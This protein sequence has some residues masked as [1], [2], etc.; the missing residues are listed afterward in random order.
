MKT[1]R[2]ANLDGFDSKYAWKRGLPIV[3]ADTVVRLQDES[4]VIIRAHETVY[5]EGSPT[6][7]ISEFQVRTHGLCP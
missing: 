7:L 1:T 2:K 3:T 6:T 5:N 4:E